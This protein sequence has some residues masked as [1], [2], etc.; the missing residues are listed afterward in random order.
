MRN[1]VE[2]IIT[3]CFR[4]DLGPVQIRCP[5][6]VLGNGHW[7]EHSFLL[8]PEQNLEHRARARVRARA[9]ARTW[10]R[11]RAL[12]QKGSTRAPFPG[13]GTCLNTLPSVPALFPMLPCDAATIM[14]SGS[15]KRCLAPSLL[16]E[17]ERTRSRELGHGVVERAP[18]L[19][20]A[21]ASKGS[22]S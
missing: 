6:P 13:T 5:C 1:R 3:L 15:E 12:P 8:V 21:L 7:S 14:A 10:A 22:C 20:G 9:R 4:N 11:A 19:N 2:Y 16:R 18:S 17:C